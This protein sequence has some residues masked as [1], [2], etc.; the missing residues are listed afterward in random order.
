MYHCHTWSHPCSW[1][2][3]TCTLWRGDRVSPP[4][5]PH[6]RAIH[7]TGTASGWT[8]SETDTDLDSF[9]L[10]YPVHFQNLTSFFFF[11]SVVLR[12][13]VEHGIKTQLWQGACVCSVISVS[14]LFLGAGR[15]VGPRPEL[16]QQAVDRTA[17]LVTCSPVMLLTQLIA[18]ALPVIIIILKVSVKGRNSL[19]H[20]A[21]VRIVCIRY[22]YLTAVTENSGG[23]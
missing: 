5:A 23:H 20:T 14:C 9:N 21:A 12:I 18:A 13:S 17:L 2:V 22:L 4:S 16:C 10:N 15:A 11:T 7:Q 8:A 3:L 6:C 1:W 19:L